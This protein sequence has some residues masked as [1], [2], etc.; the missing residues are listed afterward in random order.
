MEA[1]LDP[2]HE[3]EGLNLHIGRAIDAAR[4]L[5]HLRRFALQNIEVGPEDADDNGRTGAG[6]ETIGTIGRV[7]GWRNDPLS[8]AARHARP[9]GRQAN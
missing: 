8:D 4:G 1:D 9:T 5:A 7:R 2:R 6:Q 3:R